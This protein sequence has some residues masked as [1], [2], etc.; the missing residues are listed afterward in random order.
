MQVTKANCNEL[1]LEMW[2]YIADNADAEKMND[3]RALERAWAKSRGLTA[4]TPLCAAYETDSESCPLLKAL[5]WPDKVWCHAACTELGYSYAMTID[6]IAIYRN[7]LQ[8][9]LGKKN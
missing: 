3:I 7:V 4:R 2:N 8:D 5:K 6:D 1:M 9:I